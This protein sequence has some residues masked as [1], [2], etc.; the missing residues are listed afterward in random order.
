MSQN[1]VAV[2]D[3]WFAR[4]FDETWT[5]RPGG[6]PAL[7]SMLAVKRTADLLGGRVVVKRHGRGTA[8]S[9]GIPMQV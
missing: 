3:I 5:D 4:A 7:V 1:A 9:I 2:P 8:I 6:A